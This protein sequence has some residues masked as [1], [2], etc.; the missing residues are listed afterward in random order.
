MLT[1]LELWSHNAS[2]SYFFLLYEGRK[3]WVG[4]PGIGPVFLVVSTEVAGMTLFF[5]GFVYIEICASLGVWQFINLY[6]TVGGAQY[7]VSR[8]PREA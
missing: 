4:D 5:V 1:M 3:R 8:A 6:L 7:H 2:A